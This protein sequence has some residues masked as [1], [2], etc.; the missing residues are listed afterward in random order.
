MKVSFTKCKKVLAIIW[1]SGSGI[2]FILVLLQTLFGK[3]SGEEEKA[4]SWFLPTVMPTLSLIIGVFVA[5]AKKGSASDEREVNSFFYTLTVSLSIVFFVV[6]LIP[7]LIEPFIS[8]SIL[9]VLIRSNLW[10]G[11]LQGL[12]AAS[13]GVFFIK[14]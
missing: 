4:W 1:F 14:K 5:E 10:L 7:V 6:L 3:F 9:E 12:V 11:P 13:L 8:M 2:V